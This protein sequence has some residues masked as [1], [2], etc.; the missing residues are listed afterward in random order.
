M[1]VVL[2]IC[3]SRRHPGNSEIL[4]KEALEAAREKEVAIDFLRLPD[5]RFEP[6]RGCLACVYKGS[7]AIK[8][9]DLGILLEKVLQAD[10]LIVAAPTYLLGPAGIVKLVTDR[11]LT[12]SPHL[13]TL[14]KRHRVA[15]TISVAGNSQWNPLG[16]EQLNL[17]SLAYG[18]R[19]ID[20]LEAYAP[21]PGE[22]LL[23]PANA[24][25]ARELGRRVARALQ[26]GTGQRPVEPGQC[27]HCYS[28]SFRLN[29]GDGATC[30]VCNTTGRLIP[31]NG[32]LHFVPA[33]PG[34]EG[35]FWT[36]THRRHHLESWI[37]PSRDRYLAKRGQIKEM[38]GRYRGSSND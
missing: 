14:A 16:V 30:V 7:C 11:A 31:E 37:I 17:F 3:C 13:E 4:L 34:P 25:R 19:V 6:C 12:L 10:G 5:L 32:D 23:D 33:P 1:T 38:L 8:N 18:Y 21:G 22:V 28:R 35:H 29:G 20:Y 15:A 27:P 9:D 24:A 36:M 26:E 2:G